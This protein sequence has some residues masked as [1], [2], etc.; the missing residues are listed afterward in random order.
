[1]ETS[2]R[3]EATIDE[4]SMVDAWNWHRESLPSWRRWL[5]PVLGALHVV[6]AF[7]LIGTNYQ[8]KSI[9]VFLLVAGYIGLMLRRYQEIFFRRSVRKMPVY[10][11]TGTWEFSKGRLQI[12]LAGKL[13]KVSLAKLKQVSFTPDGW[14]FYP[15]TNVYY[16]LPCAA[17]KSDEDRKAARQIVEASAKWVE[18]AR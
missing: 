4:R 12:D 14:L 6:L 7:V 15:A 8:F 17:F 16:W 13:S 10:Q 1:M 11:K 5:F 9:S 18:L 3:A 2:V